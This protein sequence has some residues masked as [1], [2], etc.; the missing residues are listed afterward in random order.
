MGSAWMEECVSERGGGGMEVIYISVLLVQVQLW[1]G[2]G[3]DDGKSSL[4]MV[5][6][7]DVKGSVC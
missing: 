4:L 7:N 2:K 6:D 3:I 1:W 5:Y